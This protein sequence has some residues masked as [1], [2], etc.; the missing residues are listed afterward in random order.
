LRGPCLRR[1]AP[2]ADIHA[3]FVAKPTA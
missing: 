2:R 1:C 3:I